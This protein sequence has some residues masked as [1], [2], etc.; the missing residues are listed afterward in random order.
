MKKFL[1]ISALIFSFST[2]ALADSV[3]VGSDW[4]SDKIR[5]SGGT[6]GFEFSLNIDEVDGKYRLCGAW[7][8][9]GTTVS[10]IKDA[11]RLKLNGKTIVRGFGFM[12]THSGSGSLVGK[13]ARCRITKARVV[14]NPDFSIDLAKNTF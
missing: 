12:T 8:G 13:K 9:S 4:Y 1:T 5:R 14:S 6:Q 2:A 10:K 7:R 3:I 11:F